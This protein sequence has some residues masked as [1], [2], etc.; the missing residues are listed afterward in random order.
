MLGDNSESDDN[1]EEKPERPT[2]EGQFIVD[3]AGDDV[4]DSEL[5]IDDEDD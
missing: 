4:P 1:D 2:F 5:S 3:K